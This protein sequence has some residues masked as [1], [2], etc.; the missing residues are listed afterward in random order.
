LLV[1]VSHSFGLTGRPEP[2]VLET[3]GQVSI[4]ILAVIGFFGLSGWLI[5]ESRRRNSLVDF[6]RNRALRILPAY[7]LALALGA[8]AG[9]ALG[10]TTGGALEY[11]ATNL[12]I[13]PRGTPGLPDGSA[14]N[15]SLWTL[16][17][18]VLCYVALALVPER[19]LRPTIVGVLVVFTLIWPYVSGLESLLFVAFAAGAAVRVWALDV[20]PRAAALA[21]LLA[22]AFVALE[23]TTVAAAFTAIATIGLVHLP[24]RFSADLSY[25]TYVFAYPIGKL[26]AAGGFDTI[27]VT[28]LT[29]A[30]VL[31]LAALSWTFVERPALALARRPALVAA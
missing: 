30:L 21:G 15:G 31:P 26:L 8:G 13:I 25:G 22:I 14:I 29:I 3:G 12:P 10:A 7:W 11:V 16:G 4:G 1:V 17:P 23:F 18:E 28:V 24:L 19:W 9:V 20:T 6:T 5:V 2:L 27:G